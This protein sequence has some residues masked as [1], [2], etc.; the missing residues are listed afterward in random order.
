MSLKLKL[1][2]PSKTSTILIV[3]RLMKNPVTKHLVL[4]ALS[5][6]VAV[7]A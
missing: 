4:I 7:S 3:A 6:T 2:N 5:A 1:S